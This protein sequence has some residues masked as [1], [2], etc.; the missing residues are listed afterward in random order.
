MRY[1]KWNSL[2][3]RKNLADIETKVAFSR[4]T[5]V[6][7]HYDYKNVVKTT[8]LRKKCDQENNWVELNIVGAQTLFN[9]IVDNRRTK[10]WQQAWET[11]IHI[12]KI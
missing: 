5:I 4:S 8:N 3:W 11:P 9:T 1:Y 10:Y 7:V 12:T 6:N 2:D